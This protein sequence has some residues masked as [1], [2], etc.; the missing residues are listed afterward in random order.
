MKTG[1]STRELA[2]SDVVLTTYGVLSSEMLKHE[3]DDQ[4]NGGGS[5]SHVHILLPGV[6]FDIDF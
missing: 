3:A 5:S 2:L 6:A 1:R 4:A